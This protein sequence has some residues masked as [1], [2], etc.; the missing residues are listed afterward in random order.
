MSKISYASWD[1]TQ[2][3]IKI[4]GATRKCKTHNFTAGGYEVVGCN[5]VGDEVHVV[6]KL[7]NSQRASKYHIVSAA[8]AY[9]G[10][11]PM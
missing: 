9:K 7:K 6:V 11:K 8:G 3:V 1:G 10:S 4:P 2:V 5:V